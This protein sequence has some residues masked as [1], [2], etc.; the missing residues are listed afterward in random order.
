MFYVYTLTDPR[1]GA[2]FYVGKGKGLRMHQHAVEARRDSDRGNRRKIDRIKEIFAAGFEPVAEKIAEY[3]SEQE[4][5]DHEADLISVLPGLTNILARGGGWSITKEEY[6]RRQ[7]ERR[8]KWLE[9]EKLKLRERVKVWD[10]WERRGMVVTFPGLKD[11]DAL[12]QQCVD[13]VRALVA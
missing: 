5:F 8:A 6:E 12:A 4:A 9:R 7:A 1:E 2:V 10:E 11:G 3:D 13:A